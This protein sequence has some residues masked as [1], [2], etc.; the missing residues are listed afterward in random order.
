MSRNAQSK[1]M[2][3]KDRTLKKKFSVKQPRTVLYA[4]ML[5]FPDEFDAKVR[6]FAFMTSTAITGSINSLVYTNSIQHTTDDMG[7]SSISNPA[8][9]NLGR[10]Y[11]KY[12]VMSYRLDY[13][14]A[15]RSATIPTHMAVVHSPS[16]LAYGT[17]GFI[18]AAAE[19]DKGRYHFVPRI[20]QSPSI[21]TGSSGNSIMSIVGSTEFMADQDYAGTISNVGLAVAP[22]NLTYATFHQ[23]P[24]TGA[25]FVVSNSVSIALTLTQYVK[26]YDKRF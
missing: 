2:V 20:D 3:K 6:T 5:S 4:S 14:L 26:F 23:A 10:N 7:N 22:A 11:G 12:R 25:I 15:P 24:S 17:A 1:Q 8:L 18:A 16:D 19:R 9:L 13:T 21:V